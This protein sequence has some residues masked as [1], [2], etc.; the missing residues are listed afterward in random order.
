M[1]TGEAEKQLEQR[2]DVEPGAGPVQLR[3]LVSHPWTTKRR[4]DEAQVAELVELVEEMLARER[5]ADLHRETQCGEV[6][7]QL[8]VTT[9][10]CCSGEEE[11]EEKR[12]RRRAG[13]QIVAAGRGERTGLTMADRDG[14]CPSCPLAAGQ[15]PEVDGCRPTEPCLCSSAQLVPT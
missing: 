1:P 10:H 3:R 9:S 14:S 6:S 8:P 2:P 5:V 12:R 11:E 13:G 15:R 7:L 4:G